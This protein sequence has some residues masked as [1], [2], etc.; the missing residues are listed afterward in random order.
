[1][2]ELNEKQK[3]LLESVKTT[4]TNKGKSKMTAGDKYEIKMTHNGKTICFVYN[5]NIYNKGDKNDFLYAL[6]V[7]ADAYESTKNTFEFCQAFGYDWNNKEERNKA[8]EILTACCRNADKLQKLFT[9]A[10]LDMLHN[11]FE[12]Y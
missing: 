2:K 3:A 10:E 11:I 5:D 4:K 6:L 12:D 1:M 8:D 9:S 7:D